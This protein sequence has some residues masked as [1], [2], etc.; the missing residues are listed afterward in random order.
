MQLGPHKMSIGSWPLRHSAY[1]GRKR[2]CR[3]LSREIDRFAAWV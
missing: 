3:D 2:T 1:T